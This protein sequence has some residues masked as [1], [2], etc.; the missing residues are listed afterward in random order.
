MIGRDNI[1]SVSIKQMKGNFTAS[2]I[3]D[4]KANISSESEADFETEN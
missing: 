1:S 4:K 2:C 3:V